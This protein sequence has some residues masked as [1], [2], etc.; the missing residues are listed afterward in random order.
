LQL[1]QQRILEIQRGVLDTFVIDMYHL[2]QVKVAYIGD[3]KTLTPLNGFST[4][5]VSLANAATPKPAIVS[6]G[7]ANSSLL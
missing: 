3:R 5:T 6:D 7:L 2:V 1:T 4:P